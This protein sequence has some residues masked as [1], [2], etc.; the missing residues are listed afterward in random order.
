MFD[1]KTFKINKFYETLFVN[2][3]PVII[4]TSQ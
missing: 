1:E 3:L 4:R 2:N